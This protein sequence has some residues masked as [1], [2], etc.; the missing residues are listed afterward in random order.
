MTL[1]LEELTTILEAL[2]YSKESIQAQEAIAIIY[3]AI[4][5]N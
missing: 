2:Y 3:N 5:T 1:N 4:R